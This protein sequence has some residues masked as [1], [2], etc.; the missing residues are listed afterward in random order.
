MSVRKLLTFISKSSTTLRAFTTGT[1]IQVFL[2]ALHE[3]N[4]K[5]VHTNKSLGKSN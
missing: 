4:F 3:Q 1:S 2:K 5:S